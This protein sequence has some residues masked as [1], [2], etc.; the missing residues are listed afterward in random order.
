[1][2]FR[3]RKSVKLAPGVRMNFSKSGASWTLG[4]KGASVGIGKRGTDL[5]I[6]ASQELE[7]RLVKKSVQEEEHQAIDRQ[8]PQVPQVYKLPSALP[9]MELSSFKMLR[10]TPFQIT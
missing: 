5:K 8:V 10:G 3:F 9:M 1:M 6:L 2:G 7:C 4:G